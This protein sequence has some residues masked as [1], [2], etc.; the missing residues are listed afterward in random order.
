MFVLVS[1]LGLTGCTGSEP[2]EAAPTPSASRSA[3]P[4]PSPEPLSAGE[5]AQ[6]LTAL[7]PEQFDARYRLTGKG[8]R[9]DATVRMRAKGDR[10]R[11]DVTRGRSTAVLVNG[12]R[13]VISCQILD[14]QEG[15]R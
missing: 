12:P 14:Q 1:A 4:I 13:G 9:P 8:P 11:L 3:D 10:F 5:R 2:E 15:T 7:G 6:Q